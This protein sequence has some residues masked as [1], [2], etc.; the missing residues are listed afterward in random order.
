MFSKSG[1][2]TLNTKEMTKAKYLLGIVAIRNFMAAH[3]KL[4]MFSFSLALTAVLSMITG[5]ADHQVYAHISEP[6]GMLSI[7]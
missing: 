6:D 3:P 4:M 1:K 2:D 7:P 5:F